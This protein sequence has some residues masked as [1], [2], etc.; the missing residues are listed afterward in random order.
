MSETRGKLGIPLREGANV[1]VGRHPLIIAQAEFRQA[2]EAC[3]FIDGLTFDEAKALLR[4][5]ALLL[6]VSEPDT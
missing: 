3:V 5:A 6:G 4:E 1:I 2:G